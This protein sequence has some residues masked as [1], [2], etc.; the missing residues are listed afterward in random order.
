M[1]KYK[2]KYFLLLKKFNQLEKVLMKLIRDINYHYTRL[3]FNYI[4]YKI[5]QLQCFIIQRF[6]VIFN[7]I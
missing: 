3:T 4:I 7:Y 6:I 2:Y 5:Y 1:F